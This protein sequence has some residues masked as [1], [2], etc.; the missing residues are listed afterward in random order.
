MKKKKADESA[1]PICLAITFF[2]LWGK[3]HHR[4]ER[5]EPCI[6]CIVP[7]E[8]PYDYRL[9]INFK[10]EI[11]NG[12]CFREKWQLDKRTITYA[13]RFTEC[14]DANACSTAHNAQRLGHTHPTLLNKL[15]LKNANIGHLS[16]YSL[17]LMLFSSVYCCLDWSFH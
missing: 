13:T 17:N 16:K 3:C 2:C 5:E 6:Y 12:M 1:W 9:Y 11:Q 7:I 15:T 10:Y 4:I 8:N 14:W